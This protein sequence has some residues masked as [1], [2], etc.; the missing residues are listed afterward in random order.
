MSSASTWADPA[1]TNKSNGFSAPRTRSEPAVTRRWSSALRSL[2]LHRARDHLDPDRQVGPH[3]HPK[4]E[5]GSEPVLDPARDLA[6]AAT[7]QQRE[8]VVGGDGLGFAGDHERRSVAAHLVLPVDR[9]GRHRGVA[10]DPH[11]PGRG[12]HE[13]P[14]DVGHCRRGWLPVRGWPRGGAAPSAAF[15]PAASI[16]RDAS[17]GSSRPAATSSRICWMFWSAHGLN[18][19]CRLP[20]RQVGLSDMARCTYSID[21]GYPALRKAD[22]I[23]LRCS[24]PRVSSWRATSTSWMC[25]CALVRSWTTSRTLASRAANSASSCASAPGR[26]GIRTRKLR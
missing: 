23:R 19:E 1:C 7:G 9:H 10:D 12:S 14:L 18:D 4:L 13:D 6:P 2:H 15:G 3:P 26:S 11:A 20:I 21:N 22:R 25:S 24:A 8:R 5:S 17:A 16:S